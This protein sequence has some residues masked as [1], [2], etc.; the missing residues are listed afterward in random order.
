[1]GS[2]S[3]ALA[4]TVLRSVIEVGEKKMVSGTVFIFK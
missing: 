1:M 4:E 3:R 2:S